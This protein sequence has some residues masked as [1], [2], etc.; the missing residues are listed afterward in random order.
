MDR[1]DIGRSVYCLVPHGRV[2]H[3]DAKARAVL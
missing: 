3:L 2:G 1:E